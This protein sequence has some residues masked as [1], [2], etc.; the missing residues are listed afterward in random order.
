MG[1]SIT[2]K[3]EELKD[4]CSKILTAVDSNGLSEITE[5]LEL[6]LVDKILYL[7]V[8]N[9]EYFVKIKLSTEVEGEFHA[10]VHAELFLKLISKI[11][12]ELVTLEIDD[13]NLLISG[14][15][16][17]KLP[18]VYE[19]SE[20]LVLPKIEI[21]NETNSF[22]IPGSTLNSIYTYNSKQF[23]MGNII[24]PIQSLYY[25]DEQGAITF[26]TGATVN[27]FTLSSPIKLLFNSKLVKLFK[28]FKKEDVQ[29][30]IGQD[31]ISD[32]IVQTKVKFVSSDIELTAILP[33]NDA[34][35]QKVPV[36]AIRERAFKG[37]DNIAVINREELLQ[38]INR[39]SIFSYSSTAIDRTFGIFEFGA[40]EVIIKDINKVNSEKVKYSNSINIS[41]NYI[42]VLDFN[43]IKLVLETTGDEFVN[44]S[45]GD[46]QAAVFS[47]NNI[48]NVIPEIN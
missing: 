3:S 18:M 15:G 36:Q 24:N 21:M 19:G 30:K 2:L 20:L 16:K 11:T 28:L 10:T 27:K 35:V 29:F 31:Q 17:Y 38:T 14:N 45:F 42:C 4:I 40:D 41:E 25:V 8:T 43:D 6:N 5:T 48:Y 33:M 1:N 39:L 12:T 13:N 34:E 7:N 32:E 44:L 37:Y 22:T 46:H 23:S 9:R 47:R 26:T